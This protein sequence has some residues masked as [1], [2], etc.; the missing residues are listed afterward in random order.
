[1]SSVFKFYAGNIYSFRYFQLSTFRPFFFISNLQDSFG[2]FNFLI[3]ILICNHS[4]YCP[5]F[6]IIFFYFM[7]Y[8]CL[9]FFYIFLSYVVCTRS[10]SDHK[11]FIFVF[12]VFLF[13]LFSSFSSCYFF[14]VNHLFS[15]SSSLYII[16]CIIF[17]F[18]VF[19]FS[20]SVVVFILSHRSLVGLHYTCTKYFLC[21]VMYQQVNFPCVSFLTY[22]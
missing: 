9:C 20:F 1:M 14:V 21:F 19:F 2:S 3:I 8:I 11:P 17:F 12:S 16:I 18:F 22:D 4:F 6:L 7:P 5:C 10:F 15:S 13:T